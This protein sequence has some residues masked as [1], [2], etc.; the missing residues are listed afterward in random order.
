MLLRI[1]FL[2]KELDFEGDKLLWTKQKT[3]MHYQHKWLRGKAS[4]SIFLKQLSKF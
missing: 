4:G 2:K 3:I 1:A